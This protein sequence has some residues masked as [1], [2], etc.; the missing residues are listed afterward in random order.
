MPCI[1]FLRRKLKGVE[2]KILIKLIKK[3][4]LIKK[5]RIIIGPVFPSVATP[6]HSNSHGILER[7]IQVEPVSS[8]AEMSSQQETLNGWSHLE[9][10]YHP[11][12]KTKETSSKEA[13]SYVMENNT[14]KNV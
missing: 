13:Y 6:S 12:G 10:E 3:S 11:P 1:V 2:E 14:A 9:G 8:E 4:T 7:R 5:G